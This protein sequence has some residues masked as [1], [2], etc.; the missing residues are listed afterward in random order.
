MKPSLEAF[1][2]SVDR[3]ELWLS[4]ACKTAWA[5]R[6]ATALI[7]STAVTNDVLRLT[8]PVCHVKVIFNG[9]VFVM[10]LIDCLINS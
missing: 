1:R 7:D 2:S 8:R 3:E 6:L 4:A 9:E 5:V 10:C